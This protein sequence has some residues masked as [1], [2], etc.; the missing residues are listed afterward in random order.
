ML[1]HERDGT[2]CPSCEARTELSNRTAADEQTWIDHY[3]LLERVIDAL[4]AELAEVRNQ[5]ADA[6]WPLNEPR[7]AKAEASRA[8][9]TRTEVGQ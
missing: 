5:R 6:L 3:D 2:R 7:R 8:G 1:A 4:L 9:I